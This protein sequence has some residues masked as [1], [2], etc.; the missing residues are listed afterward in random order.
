[1]KIK[2]A[3][4]LDLPSIVA[5][6]NESIPGRLAT[7]DTELVSIES[8]LEWFRNHKNKRPLW[9]AE[10]NQEI[11]GWVS[12]QDFYGRC[13][14]QK[15]AEFSIYIK[16][17]YQRQGVAQKLLSHLINECYSLEI[18]TLLGFIFA[19]NHPSIQLVKKFGFEEWGYLPRIA[20]LDGME[21]DLKIFGLK[22]V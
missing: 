10:K 11:I 8:R 7:A 5:I 15:T 22:I 16:S 19:H 13:A 9:V 18:S 1:M 12:L 21:K 2:I 17:A 6:Y 3:S 20:H 14:Y 4:E